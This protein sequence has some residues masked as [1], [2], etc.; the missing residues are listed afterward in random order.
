MAA[1]D[2]DSSLETG[3]ERVD[4]QH[5][6][7]FGMLNEVVEAVESGEGDAHV[8]NVLERLS[9]YVAVHFTEEQSL[10]EGVGL[11][12]DE[13]KLHTAAHLELTRSTREFI[14][15]WRA[16]QVEATELADFLADWLTGH[17]LDKD[18][19]LARFMRES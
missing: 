6:A 1:Y 2:W 16:R 18:Q 5:R 9:E 19:A 14:L 17:I 13:L 3:N 8:G 10:M 4:S 15:Q 12:A 11:P 7:L